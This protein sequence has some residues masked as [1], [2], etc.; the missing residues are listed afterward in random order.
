MM[1]KLVG[2]LLT[3]LRRKTSIVSVTSTNGPVSSWPK[4]TAMAAVFHSAPAIR[5]LRGAE[6]F[7]RKHK[8]SVPLRL[9]GSVIA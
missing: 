9:E 2:A 1:T 7:Y 6:L 8:T 5:Q 4:R 3:P